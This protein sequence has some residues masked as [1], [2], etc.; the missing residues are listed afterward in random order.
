MRNAQVS[1]ALRERCPMDANSG[2]KRNKGGECEFGRHD[3]YSS[4]GC[5]VTQEISLTHMSIRVAEMLS[6]QFDLPQA[7]SPGRKREAPVVGIRHAAEAVNS[8]RKRNGRT[9]KSDEYERW[10]RESRLP[11]EYISSFAMMCALHSACDYNARR[12]QGLSLGRVLGEPP[13]PADMAKSAS[14]A[15]FEGIKPTH[16]QSF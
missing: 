2:Q 10:M 5:A 8:C 11:L 3:T 16:G 6:R 13:V 1:A 4:S 7:R 15:P 14:A 12:E 9:K